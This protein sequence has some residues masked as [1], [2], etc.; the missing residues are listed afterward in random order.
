MCWCKSLFLIISNTKT[1]T[2]HVRNGKFPVLSDKFFF[3]LFRKFAI[4]Y[5]EQT[6]QWL[7]L[8]YLVWVGLFYN[9][10]FTSWVI[11]NRHIGGNL[12]LLTG[13][14]SRMCRT[15]LGSQYGSGTDSPISLLSPRGPGEKSLPNLTGTSCTYVRTYRRTKRLD[16]CWNIIHNCHLS[17]LVTC[18]SKKSTGEINTT[19][20]ALCHLSVITRPCQWAW[21]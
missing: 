18:H 13:S 11:L 9:P 15:G 14:I 20:M 4:T 10:S 3:N 16:T 7:I 1:N 12:L 2:S 17:L 19:K 6:F 5:S 21:M 8:K